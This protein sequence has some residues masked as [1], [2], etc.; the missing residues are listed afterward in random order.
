MGTAMA[1]F[2]TSENELYTLRT[3]IMAEYRKP[4]PSYERLK[5]WEHRFAQ[6]YGSIDSDPRLRLWRA[7]ITSLNLETRYNIAE[8]SG[9]KAALAKL[10]TARRSNSGNAYFVRN[11]GNPPIYVPAPAD[12]KQVIAVMPDGQIKTL[13]YNARQKRWEGNY[14]IPTSMREGDY[15][16]QIIA[17]RADNSRTFTKL[18]FRVDTTPPTGSG[19]V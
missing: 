2:E 5:T 14:D 6:L 12:A 19:R 7:R 9:D 3:K 1:A 17:V 18:K 4:H 8:K 10:K 15:A 11:I 16:I 13:E